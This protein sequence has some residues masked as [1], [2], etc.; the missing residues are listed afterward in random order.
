M[1]SDVAPAVGEEPM[2]Q[3][4]EQKVFMGDQNLTNTGM[5]TQGNSASL[6]TAQDSVEVPGETDT[7]DTESI[8]TQEMTIDQ[9]LSAESESST[10]TDTQKELTNE[11]TFS[12]DEHHVESP[13]TRESFT[14]KCVF[15]DK[16]LGAA[17]NPKLLECLH[18]VCG[19]CINSRLYEHGDDSHQVECPLCTIPC[20]A[21]RIIDNQF[22]LELSAS[23]GNS[24]GSNEETTSAT[25]KPTE[26]KC[27]SCSDDADATSYCVDC[28]E[29]ICDNCVQAHQRLKITKDHTIKPKEDGLIE[30][31]S[32]ASGSGLNSMFCQQHPHEK[33]SLF[34]ETCDMLTCRDC[35]LIEHREHKYKFTNEI[36]SEARKFIGEMLKDVG[37]K[38]ALLTSAMKVIED[39][40]NLITEKKHALVREITQLV[41]KLTNTINVRGKQLV[42]KLSEVCESKQKTLHEKKQALE[43]LSKMT[44]HCISFTQ[45]ALD[46]GSDMALLYSKKQ[47]TEH[48][49]R[50]KC[51]RA[52]IPNPEIPV[53]IHLALDK[54]PDLIKVMAT[55]GQ[56]VVD[57]RIYPSEPVSPAG[58][59]GG[60]QQQHMVPQRP[61]SLP[62]SPS[63][64]QRPPQQ[65]SPIDVAQQHQM[66]SP[67]GSAGPYPTHQ[68]RIQHA[69]P[70][71]G[72]TSGGQ[73]Q[74]QQYQYQQ[75]MQQQQMQGQQSRLQSM[76][77][78]SINNIPQ[79]IPI[80]LT[81]QLN[82]KPMQRPLPNMQRPNVARLPL[83]LNQQQQQVSSSTHPSG[84]LGE[85]NNLRH[86]LQPNTNSGGNPIYIQTGPGQYQAIQPHIVQQF[87]N[88]FPA[89]AA[90]QGQQQIRFSHQPASNQ[91]R[92]LVPNQSPQQQQ[93]SRI[94]QHLQQQQSH[95]QQQQR[96]PPQYQNSM[97]AIGGAKWHTP[98]QSMG[99]HHQQQQQQRCGMGGGMSLLTTAVNDNF[100]ITLRQQ[101]V[102][103]TSTQPATV[104][105][106]P[107]ATSADKTVSS[108]IPKTPSPKPPQG[109]SDTE[110]SLDKFCEDSVKDLMA[111]IAKLDSN[112]VQVLAEGR[113]KG[114]SPHVDSSTG[115]STPVHK[116]KTELS[117][118]SKDDPNEDW[119]AV[120]MDGGEL[121]CCDKCPKVFH[122]YC[123]IPNLSV[124]END[125]WQC[126]LCMNFADLTENAGATDKNGHELSAKEKKTAERLVLELYCQYEPSLHFREVIGS[127]NTEY[128]SI[129]KKPI[130]LDT[131]RQKLN[132]GSE[133]QYR[134]LADLVK[135]VRLMF[136]NAY[137]FN[138]MDS[139]VYQDAKTLEKFFDEQLEKFLP[140][141]AYEQFNDDEEEDAELR[142]PG[143][144]YRKVVND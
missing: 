141:F 96:P 136:R 98:Q 48:L 32:V 3:T 70:N 21:D 83:G 33:L 73:E 1:E 30:S 14:F 84:I 100:K 13:T 104:T 112:G 15:C 71:Y 103:G 44:D 68:Q 77:P 80:S 63:P 139:Q 102:P 76:G 75:Q 27:S 54:V 53:R 127:E 69:A 144:K 101:A 61:P 134:N 122:Q 123:H 16:V 60:S 113:Q 119:C 115:D 135:D 4:M 7:T 94:Q 36:A 79:A 25:Q 142:P 57:G 82:M 108:T 55:I 133:N 22:L 88:R 121:V 111:T 106:L 59:G 39:R 6:E 125:T 2:E 138:P 10:Y 87:Q 85:R 11:S 130:A 131:I 43:Q 38:R 86:L 124:E 45:N 137:T 118:A 120:C 65:M 129:I 34:C 40:Q 117:E 107:Q 114:S 116:I 8:K 90:S 5:E 58:I 99:G 26:L 81:Q 93:L 72:Q 132:W 66:S 37:Y 19:G 49:K 92:M 17:D 74:Q 52:D 78:P 95:Q 41:V 46:N 42:S 56:I 62:N 128:H 12:N 97:S 64:H 18:N 29:F 23:A 89:A 20:T 9:L 31:N 67:T 35:Q 51:K 110:R 143:R 47:V 24:C 28:S 126:L 109:K 91:M 50:I 105:T 140:E